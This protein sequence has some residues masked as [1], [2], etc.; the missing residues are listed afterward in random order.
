MLIQTER[1]RERLCKRERHGV[2]MHIPNQQ[3]SYFEWQKRWAEGVNLGPYSSNEIIWHPFLDEI[4]YWKPD[5]H[6][7]FFYVTQIRRASLRKELQDNKLS[8]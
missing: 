6:I 7:V 3:Q 2:E 4:S 1:E 5:M 8:L